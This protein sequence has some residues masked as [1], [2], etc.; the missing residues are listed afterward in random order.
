MKRKV[1]KELKE[2]KR[3][4]REYKFNQK[5]LEKIGDDIFCEGELVENGK[6]RISENEKWINV[7][8][9]LRGDFSQTLSNLFPYEFIFRGKKLKCIENFFQGLN[10]KNKKEQNLLFKYFGTQN[11]RVKCATTYNWKD[12]GIVYWQGKGINRFSK[13]YDDIVDELYICAIQNPLYRSILKKCDKDIIHSMGKDNKRD[14]TYTRL[15]LE[16]QL[17]CLKDFLKQ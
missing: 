9:N 11:I 15:E 3:F 14:S 12:S 2:Y 4:K 8:Y 16:T 6:E 5:I 13:E 1:K 10:F 7:G 17:N